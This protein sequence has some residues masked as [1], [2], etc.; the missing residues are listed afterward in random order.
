M[1]GILRLLVLKRIYQFIVMSHSANKN[2]QTRNSTV[3]DKPRDA[4]L[5][6]PNLLYNAPPHMCY[7]AEF[8]RS[9]SIRV[10]INSGEPAKLRSRHAALGWMACL[11]A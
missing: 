5:G 9:R 8:G 3:A 10:R 1:F 4:F 7:H 6:V 11:T 2:E